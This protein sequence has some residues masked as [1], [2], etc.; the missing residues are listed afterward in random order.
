MVRLCLLR[1]ALAT[2]EVHTSLWRGA[3]VVGIHTSQHRR[4]CRRCRE[5]QALSQMACGSWFWDAPG[6]DLAAGRVSE[7]R[8]AA[9]FVIRSHSHAVKGRRPPV[10]GK[11]A[12]KPSW[13]TGPVPLARCAD[14]PLHG[15]MPSLSHRTAPVPAPSTAILPGSATNSRLLGGCATSGTSSPS[16]ANSIS[17]QW[18]RCGRSMVRCTR[19]TASLGAVNCELS[20]VSGICPTCCGPDLLRAPALRQLFSPNAVFQE[21]KRA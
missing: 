17:P 14:G 18:M 4:G 9:I 11:A 19:T 21:V 16:C 20:T 15:G 2:E 3:P 8:T 7:P 5:S 6:P 1:R 10:L 13:L 12:D